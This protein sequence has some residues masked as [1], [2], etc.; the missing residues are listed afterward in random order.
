MKRALAGGLTTLVAVGLVAIANVVNA[1]T[2]WNG[3]KITFSKFRGQDETNPAFQD[4]IT[5]RVWL[6]RGNTRGLYN[7]R[8]ESFFSRGVSPVD[9][10]WAFGTT[11][12][13]PNLKFTDWVAFHGGCS[14][15]Q[16][17]R[18]AVV[19]LISEDIYIDI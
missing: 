9:T 17:G 8:Q 7:I 11:A 3:P 6:T 2:I 18:N 10:E 1:A 5:P 15:C 12:D 14:P 19:H 13:L 4:R 16:V